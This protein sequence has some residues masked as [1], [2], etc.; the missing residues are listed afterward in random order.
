MIISCRNTF[1]SRVS[2]NR[3][4]PIESD[5]YVNHAMSSSLFEEATITP[6]T[7]DDIRDF[8][9][10]YVMDG[11]AAES[12]GCVSVSSQDEYLRWLRAIPDVMDL[13]KN[14]FL[15]ILALKA[16]SSLS[17]D[18][19]DNTNLEAIRLYLYDHF[20]KEWFQVSEKRIAQARLSPKARRAY[21]RLHEEDFR[22]CARDYSIRLAT[23]MYV[24][25]G[26]CA[27]VEYT[28]RDDN[29]S[30]KA[31]FFGED[32][33]TTLL[34]EASPLS[35]VGTQY[36]FIHQSLLDYFAS[37]EIFDF[38]V[39]DGGDTGDSSRDDC[40]GD[41]ITLS[42]GSGNTSGGSGSS[43]G[44]NMDSSGDNHSSTSGNGSTFERTDSSG[45]GTGG[46]QGDRD[47]PQPRNDDIC[48]KRNG[49]SDASHASTSSELLTK[50]NLFKTPSVLQFLVEHARS[51]PR[52]K[53][54]MLLVIK[55]SNLL[56]NS[57]LAGANAITILFKS[58][59]RFLNIDLDG[60]QVPFN[61]TL[62]ETAGSTMLVTPWTGSELLDVLLASEAEPLSYSQ[63]TPTATLTPPTPLSNET[64][65]TQTP[66][67]CSDHPLE[68]LGPQAL[69]SDSPNST[70]RIRKRDKLHE[71][72][73]TSKS[74]SKFK[75]ISTSKGVKSMTTK[76]LTRPSSIAS[77]VSNELSGNNQTVTSPPAI[78]EANPRSSLQPSPPNMASIVIA[79][80]P[81]N[82]SKPVIKIKLPRL[83]ERIESTE[84][85][86]YCT[87]LLLPDSMPPAA[88]SGYDTATD[89]ALCLQESTLDKA[90]L[91]WL[92]EIKKDPMEQD[93]FRWLLTQMV[94]AFVADTTKDSDELAEIVTLG[95]VLQKE[96][97]RKLLSS[98]I[99]DFDD[100]RILDVN[101][102]QGLV[103]F[104]QSAS[105]DYL[106][107]DDLVKILSILRTCLQGI[108]HQS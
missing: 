15:L 67:P 13:A 76:Q 56:T 93:H 95:P 53:K 7:E 22:E 72:L 16:V 33:K 31:A 39:S 40:H 101:L 97:Y 1:L 12:F 80:F 2:E 65:S 17:G 48:S 38:C 32:H 58:G 83:H 26:G 19:L 54:H 88:V 62:K 47:G 73:G 75:S 60:V 14:P 34:R 55:Q 4:H 11:M 20:A 92:E 52:F 68:Q 27:F 29:Q 36:R 3:F 98:L 102:L 104:V 5:K 99:K 46:S 6:F 25:N 37:L 108:H 10:R 61:Y 78:Q 44:G 71:L 45:E 57:D 59:E 24:K 89:A 87:S 35:R 84:Q 41:E 30:W 106:V 49:L 21:D 43:S 86:V 107:S 66:T 69:G 82:V 96:P 23:A 100:A 42:G 94:E 77:Q 63:A 85:L 79:I 51:N 8:I 105:S 70:V 18:A 103:E 91:D 74:I 9:T 64:Q 28:H 50:L 81:D 90:E